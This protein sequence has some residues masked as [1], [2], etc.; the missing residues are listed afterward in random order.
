MTIVTSNATNFVQNKIKKIEGKTFTLWIGG[1]CE[2]KKRMC[3][4]FANDRLKESI[5]KV[6]VLGLN[7]Y[8]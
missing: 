1:V 4:L 2:K 5:E 3:I 7:I 6:E 8:F